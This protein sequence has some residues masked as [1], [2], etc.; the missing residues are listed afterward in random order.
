MLQS[1]RRPPGVCFADPSILLIESNPQTAYEITDMLAQSND[2][3]TVRM[4]MNVR[5]GFTTIELD[6]VDA[7][8]YDAQSA[9]VR[10]VSPMIREFR[11]RLPDAAILILTTCTHE[12]WAVQAMNHGAT[13]VLVRS[14]DDLPDVAR[15][16]G[17]ALERRR[18]A[19]A[20]SLQASR[21]KLTQLANRPA[22][23]QAVQLASRDCLVRSGRFAVMFVDLDGFKGINDTLGH[24]GGDRALCEVARRLKAEMRSGDLVARIGGDEFALL[25]N[26]VG[27]LWR[28]LEIA[29]RIVDAVR[30]PMLLS[31]VEVQLGCR[32]GI[33]LYPQSGRTESE[34]LK[35]ADAA[36]YAAKGGASAIRVHLPDGVPQWR[37]RVRE[38]VSMD[39]PAPPPER[40]ASP[41]S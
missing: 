2:A 38:N 27:H 36:M 13:Q 1:H 29:E 40:A 11:N 37:G 10:S 33:A 39:T 31:G 12:Q 22:L 41:N 17:V 4:A 23:S 30:R 18:T 9:D 28:P 25:V 15:A 26:D 6:G 35:A 8:V 24:A 34:L 3:Y 5:D 14:Y 19:N 7:V 20:L 21:D 32:V 16:V